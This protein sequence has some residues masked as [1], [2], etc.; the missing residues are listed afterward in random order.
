L[1]ER[2]APE[3]ERRLE[4]LE[5]RDTLEL[6]PDRLL[7]LT[8]RVRFAELF[9]DDRVLLLIRASGTVLER[10]ALRS[11]ERV[12]PS[13]CTAVA[14]LRDVLTRRLSVCTD[15]ALARIIASRWV[16]RRL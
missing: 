8:W 14:R 12:S 16:A 11:I 5:E 15:L 4:R 10:V 1:P 2:F 6:F 7:L 3:V 9:D 13:R